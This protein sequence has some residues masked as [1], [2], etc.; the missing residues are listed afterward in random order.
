MIIPSP[1]ELRG[2]SRT[3]L[4][5]RLLML[6]SGCGALAAGLGAGGLPLLVAGAGAL[7]LLAALIRPGGLG[8]GVVIGGAAGAWLL[9]YGVDQPPVAG[10]VALTLALGLHHQAAA[11][12]AA[13]PVRAGVHRDVLIRFARH[14]A[15]VLALTAVVAAIALGITRPGGST[16]LELLG[17]AAAVAAITVPVL[18]SRSR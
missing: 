13:L 15:L 2:W 17:L 4:A 3:A 8:P 10:T 7:G 5:L 16:P 1:S 6:V 14:G 11:L 18:L 12:A 9:R